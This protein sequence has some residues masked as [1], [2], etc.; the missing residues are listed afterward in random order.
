LIVGAKEAPPFSMKARCLQPAKLDNG[1]SEITLPD[2]PWT[3]Q[4]RRD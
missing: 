3:C 1:I 2:M 4:N